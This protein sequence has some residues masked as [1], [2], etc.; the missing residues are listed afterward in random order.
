MNRLND[1]INLLGGDIN[2][3]VSKI[4]K[5]QI[6]ELANFL[7]DII[8]GKTK[9]NQLPINSIKKTTL[10]LNLQKIVS[11]TLFKEQRSEA[12][13]I[14]FLIT[15]RDALRPPTRTATASVGSPAAAAAAAFFTPGADEA[16]ATAAGAEAIAQIEAAAAAAVAK[17]PSSS[18]R[19]SSSSSTEETPA[20]EE[21]SEEAAAE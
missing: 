11:D 14:Q 1:Y 19:S 16:A 17:A 8:I 9:Y 6:E 3:I 13:K 5:D 20:A 7:D 21:A 2:G 4:S 18:S 10:G 12:D 15:L